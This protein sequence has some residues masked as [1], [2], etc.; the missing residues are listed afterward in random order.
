MAR[1]DGRR[2]LV[3]ED[4]PIIST[5]VEEH[6]LDAGASVVA[7]AA[8]LK[9][10]EAMLASLLP[11]GVLLDLNLDGISA[12][13]LAHRLHTMQVP[14]VVTTGYDP[15]AMPPGLLEEVMMKPYDFP[16][17]VDAVERMYVPVA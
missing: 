7:L 1:L 15:E 10:A 17:L 6:L 11:D 13:P 14:F 2:I 4:E 3:V 16:R 9:E 8:S 12:L 5:L